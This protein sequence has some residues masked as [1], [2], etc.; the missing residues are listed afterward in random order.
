MSSSARAA[1]YEYQVV[2]FVGELKRGVLNI[3][4]ARKVSDQ[5]QAVIATYTR[6]GW[7]FYRIDK[8]DVQVTPGCLASLLGARVSFITFDQVIFRRRVT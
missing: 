5:L 6:Q 8:V 7:E 2:P 1:E 3:E 4:N